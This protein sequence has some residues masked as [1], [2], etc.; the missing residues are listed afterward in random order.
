MSEPQFVAICALLAA[1]KADT[2]REGPLQ[3]AWSWLGC[4][5][6]LAAIVMRLT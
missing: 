4:I 5:G 1:I 3:A 2:V 6:L